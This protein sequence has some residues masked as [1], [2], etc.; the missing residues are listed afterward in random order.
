MATLAAHLIPTPPPHFDPRPFYVEA[1]AS[2]SPWTSPSFYAALAATG[3][4][5][6]VV[7]IVGAFGRVSANKKEAARPARRP[8]SE[9]PV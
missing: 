9:L 8:F 4:V 6:G 1:T 7:R 2:G 5:L 3:L